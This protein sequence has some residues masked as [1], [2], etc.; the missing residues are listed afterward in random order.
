MLIYII[1]L[2]TFSYQCIR[3]NCLLSKN[4][5]HFFAV[6]IQSSEIL[7]LRI[8]M[9]LY[10]PAIILS[11]VSFGIVFS[12]LFI[13]GILQGRKLHVALDSSGVDYLVKAGNCAKEISWLGIAGLV[14]V[15]SVSAYQI[16]FGFLGQGIQ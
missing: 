5:E 10:L 6:G 2:I 14:Y 12:V 1:A 7:K 11:I 4:A 3:K 16:M 15:V 9:W 8:F 13:P